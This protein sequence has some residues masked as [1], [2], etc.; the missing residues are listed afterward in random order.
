M[1]TSDK[2]L[3]TQGENKLAD[4][5]HEQFE[6]LSDEE[7][8]Q[9]MHQSAS[10]GSVFEKNVYLQMDRDAG[11]TFGQ[12]FFRQDQAKKYVEGDEV[13][14]IIATIDHYW[15]PDSKHKVM[16]ED[17]N[18]DTVDYSVDTIPSLMGLPDDVTPVLYKNTY[19]MKTFEN[20]AKERRRFTEVVDALELTNG[21]IDPS[22]KSEYG[23]A[24]VKRLHVFVKD[25]EGG[26]NYEVPVII[27]C[28]GYHF[29]NL[30]NYLNKPELQNFVVKVKSLMTEEPDYNNDKK[31]RKMPVFDYDITTTPL[32]KEQQ[33]QVLQMRGKHTKDLVEA[34]GSKVTTEEEQEDVSIDSETPNGE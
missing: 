28:S 20:G 5:S 1:S 15:R 23:L 26:W 31:M 6:R 7:R 10:T 29:K 4:L 30:I 16:Q 14:I 2:G 8:E 33:F 19:P 17:W 9:L 22:V 24:M 32:D 27:S 25:D 34:F 21:N 3:T 13:E 18:D 11:D 12:M